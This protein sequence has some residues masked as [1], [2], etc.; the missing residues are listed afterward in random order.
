MY[1]GLTI[2]WLYILLYLVRNVES[3]TFYLMVLLGE[4]MFCSFDLES[5]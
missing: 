4:V 2:D 5:M 3:L 1:S